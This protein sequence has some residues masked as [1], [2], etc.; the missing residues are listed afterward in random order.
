MKKRENG[1][2]GNDRFGQ[3]TSREP[4]QAVPNRRQDGKRFE[5]CSHVHRMLRQP[6][7]GGLDVA[8]E[9]ARLPD[10]APAL[11][12]EALGLFLHVRGPT[13]R[14][15]DPAIGED[16]LTPMEEASAREQAETRAEREAAVRR[17]VEAENARLRARIRELERSARAPE[18]PRY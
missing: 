3:L 10:G 14:L 5:D 6:E 11:Y 8:V 13:L 17:A 1:K 7:T 9:V 16:L 2:P 12:S 15:Y 18:P 4:C